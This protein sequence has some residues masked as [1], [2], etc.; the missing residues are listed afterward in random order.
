MTVTTLRPLPAVDV[1]AVSGAC[2][3]PHLGLIRAQGAD[4][5]QFLHNQLSQDFLNLDAQHAHL[6]AFC[7]AKG[8]MQASLL[9]V[10]LQDDELLLILSRD[11][12][13]RTLKR[14]RMFV[15]RA[16]VQ[17]SDA[18]A[19]YAL[20]GLLGHAV[21]Q[22]LADA[23]EP[24]RVFHTEAG[25]FISLY[26]AAGQVAQA[27]YLA[28]AP[29][30]APAQPEHSPALWQWA[31]VLS[32]IATL[33]APVFEQFVPQMLNYESVGGVNFKKGCYPGQEIIAR[34]QFRGS[35]KR[36]AFIASSNQALEAGQDVFSAQRPDQPVGV[37]VQAA[38]APAPAFAQASEQAQYFAIVSMQINALDEEGGL[39]AG[40][41][42]GAVL[43]IY[44]LPYSLLED[45]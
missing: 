5:A 43:D 3:L 14:L 26:P 25:R 27:L 8:R 45:I 20:W 19:D 29:C 12:L 21:P 35:I 17:L 33:S 1:N 28:P 13:E 39:F 38:P 7:N 24:G 30:S 37:V 40:A 11:L 10:K 41:V 23:A 44:E 18:T 6:A 2:P 16:K 34:S 31:Q 42:N 9:G 4:A 36:R 22:S 32:G 15:L